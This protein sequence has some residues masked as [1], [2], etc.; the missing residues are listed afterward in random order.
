MHLSPADGPRR[1]EIC[2]QAVLLLGSCQPYGISD[3]ELGGRFFWSLNLIGPRPGRSTQSRLWSATRVARV[4]V[5]VAPE[6]VICA[7]MCQRIY[8]VGGMWSGGRGPPTASR[9]LD[10][11]TCLPRWPGTAACPGMGRAKVPRP[12]I[13]LIRGTG[14]APRPIRLEASSLGG[15]ME[16]SGGRSAPAR[17]VVP[18]LPASGRQTRSA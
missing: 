6:R 9:Q 16:Q 15:S 11:R 2:A 18:V 1:V 7:G 13:S 17:R 8:A 5:V 14:T 3:Q 4:A 10:R 12:E